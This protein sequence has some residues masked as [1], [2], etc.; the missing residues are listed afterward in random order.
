MKNETN[1]L[2]KP[3]GRYLVQNSSMHA[4]QDDRSYAG[5]FMRE[6]ASAVGLEP[7]I[8]VLQNYVLGR[9]EHVQR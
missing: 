8:Q 6:V 7:L 2:E 4:L 5:D 9:H 1:G 3:L